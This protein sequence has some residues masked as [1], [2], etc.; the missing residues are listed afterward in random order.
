MACGKENTHDVLWC[1]S[2]LGGEPLLNKRLFGSHS[3][4]RAH[5]GFVSFAC[6]YLM[7]HRSFEGIMTKR[8]E[9]PTLSLKQI[10]NAIRVVGFECFVLSCFVL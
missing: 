6:C 8:A 1:T 3:S 9:Y 2:R 10:D 5:S 7:C 4:W